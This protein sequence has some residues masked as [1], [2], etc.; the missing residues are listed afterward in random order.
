MNTE[1]HEVGKTK[2]AG[3]QIGV[4]K[5]IACSFKV[6][7]RL[8][9]SPEGLMI[10]SG[11]G[12]VQGWMLGAALRFPDGTHGQVRVFE[13]N[14]HIRIT[15]HPPGW[16]RPSI[17]QVRIIDHGDRTVI[18]FHQEQL[19]DATQREQRRACFRRAMGKLEDLPQN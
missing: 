12:S 8:I 18:A 5:T 2:N 1:A 13:P 19:P 6:A 14:S 10:W 15:W 17:I 4:R 9:A 7:W 16:I 11:G 3:S